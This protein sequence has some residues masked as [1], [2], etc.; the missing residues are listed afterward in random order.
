MD[1]PSG[2]VVSNRRRL[3]LRIGAVAA[4]L[5][6]L[7]A[8]LLWLA[9]PRI[10]ESM[11]EK[12]LASLEARTGLN[13][14][15]ESFETVGREGIEIRGLSIALPD[16][17]APLGQIE[18]ID[19]S[20]DLVQAARGRP[21]FSSLD[22]EGV[23]LTL[24]RYGD[25][26]TDL[27]RIRE[28]LGDAEDD[29][30]E[31]DDDFDVLDLEDRLEAL[32]ERGLRYFGGAYPDLV[33]RQ[34][35]L[36]LTHD[37][38]AQPWPIDS[39]STDLFTLQGDHKRAPFE[40][41]LA[42]DVP[43][44]DS[45][46][47]PESVQLSGSLHRPVFESLLRVDFE[48]ELR[49]S[50]LA[51]L[52]FSELSLTGFEV[53]ENYTLLLRQPR[54]DSRL[55]PNSERLAS[56]QQV[57][58]S[59][60]EWT[61]DR[62]ALSIVEL[63]VDEPRVYIEYDA[64]GASNLTQLNHILRQPRARSTAAHARR[65]ATLIDEANRDDDDD[66]DDDASDAPTVDPN[67]PV[68]R[69]SSLFEGLPVQQWLTNYLPRQTSLR[70]V[71]IVVDDAREHE[72]L[73]RPAS[74]F[75]I[76]AEVLELEHHP[77]RGILEGDF[78]FQVIAGDD[79]ART[80]IE[81]HIPYRQGNW[82]VSVD[83]DALELAHF[84]QIFGPRL[85]QYLHGGEVTATLE[86]AN[87]G[88][89]GGAVTRFD[90]LLA[91]RDFRVHM[92]AIAEDPIEV[93]SASLLLDGSYDPA[94]PV[95]PPELVF[96]GYS[97]VDSDPAAE[98]EDDDAQED[99]YPFDPPDRGAFV[100]DNARAQLSD[101]E[102]QFSLAIHGID[103][104][105]RP[106]R[107]TI[108]VDLEP[109][110]LSA[111]IDAVPA[112]IR[113]P[114]DGLEMRGDLTW[115]YKL[116]VPLY[117]ASTMA[118]EADVHLSPDF[119]IIYIPEPVDVFKLT[120]EFEHTITDEWTADVRWVERD[121]F[122]ERT[123]TIPEMTPI[124]AT[125]ILENTG[126]E[127]SRLDG[128]RRQREWPPVPEWSPYL[129]LSRAVLDSPEYWLTSHALDKSTSRPPWAKEERQAPAEPS[130][131]DSFFQ[132]FEEGDSAAEDQF[133]TPSTEDDDAAGLLIYEK[134]EPL[135][136]HETEIQVDPDRYGPYVF[137]PLHHISPYMVRAILTT[138]DTSFFTHDGFNFLAIRHSVEANLEAGRY[139]RGA[140]TIS[141]QL[142]KNVFLDRSRVLSR[143]LQEVA[144][145]WLMESVADVPKER[146]MEVY[147]NVIE[148]GPG[149]FGINEAA[150]HYFG[151][152]PDELTISESA[153]LVSIVPN[154]K[155]YHQYYDR[156]EITPGWFRRM[157]RYI[158]AMYNRDR[159]TEV[160]M[161]AAL[162]IVPQ[163]YI[164][165]DGDPLLREDAGEVVPSVEPDQAVTTDEDGDAGDE[166]EPAV[167]LFD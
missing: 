124:P 81:F 160:E 131:V 2:K 42:L 37:E 36:T 74:R 35:R 48:D 5:L 31:G 55:G 166:A 46:Q 134:P 13:I 71:R 130:F 151:K 69:F 138:E 147:L 47:I 90:G 128:I 104:T 41:T 50:N 120:D 167:P 157:S 162:E 10:I 163:F 114:L 87:A 164:P 76:T 111:I 115:K 107:V 146:L 45:L 34:A 139:V 133:N 18:A 137:V 44:S 106:N 15:V 113:G 75:E 26:T 154:P 66:G 118:W 101:L 143:K 14:D 86:V 94:L 28:G 117:E 98:D 7:L 99:P 54:I 38:G 56:A 9:T 97:V 161:E 110:P 22:I 19:A 52:P 67:D 17:D 140:S 103:G 11:V 65:I 62:S 127:L 57:S 73:T 80:D 135:R 125:W 51:R 148:F 88:E 16:G 21:A 25:G 8:G 96:R 6:I 78:K 116:E 39:V 70:D 142:V 89:D 24:H 149:I 59:F 102:T 92:P 58:T 85:A 12:Q 49:V 64:H 129:G 3:I 33:V 123:V 82:D 155:R 63:Q 145:V 79:S 156:G 91:L 119:E 150:M 100:I 144:L 4:G 109:T 158:R 165:E 84:S 112:A 61:T 1:K 141:M 136:P 60:A 43:H 132:G 108:E 29:D 30:D 93:P 153:W 77:L 121:F 83:I 159:I 27:D 53:A 95:P 23:A 152:R 20:I 72:N 122:Y 126:I 68:A 105:N 40:M 32:A